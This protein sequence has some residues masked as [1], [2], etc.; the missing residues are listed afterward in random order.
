MG[1]ATLKVADDVLAQLMLAMAPVTGIDPSRDF[2]TAGTV[3][4]VKSVPQDPRLTNE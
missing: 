3:A 2:L 1:K 4:G